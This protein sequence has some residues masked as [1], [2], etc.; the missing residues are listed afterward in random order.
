MRISI[1]TL[2]PEMFSGVFDF[3]ITKRAVSKQLLD[4]RYIQ[5]RDFASDAY[6]SVDDHPYGGGVGMVLRVDVVDKAIRHARASQPTG[7]TR[8]ILLD[9]QGHSYT[10][11]KARELAKIDHVI[12]LCGH[13][14]GV[15]ERV[16]SLVDEELSIGDYILTG[17]EIP[18]MV[19]TDSV[20]RLIHGVLKP[21]ATTNESFESSLLEYPQYTRPDSY[22]GKTVPLELKSGNHAAI[23]TWKNQKALQRTKNR[24]PDLLRE[25]K[26]SPSH[27][28]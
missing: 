27:A 11:Q 19:V 18:A 15:D 14:E 28:R 17:G 8:V 7:S 24:R 26:D 20:T 22:D 16:R 10:Q 13:Y 9:P 4:I 21:D 6:G 3:S 5:L 1:I 25:K 12:L 2:F 23:E